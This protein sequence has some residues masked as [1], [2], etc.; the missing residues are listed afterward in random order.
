M[1]GSSVIASEEI[2]V[3]RAKTGDRSAFDELVGL[4]RA[5]LESWI[6]SRIGGRLRHK[7]D[8]DDL[9]QETQLRALESVNRFSWRGD[10]S[11]G[12]WL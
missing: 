7:V 10:G 2:L 9:T 11:F 8:V 5:R 12:G 4:N 6:R 1:R 3:A